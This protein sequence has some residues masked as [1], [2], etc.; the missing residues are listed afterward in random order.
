[1]SKRGR[2]SFRAGWRKEESQP[3]L[4]A[5]NQ[6]GAADRL[7]G[8]DGLGDEGGLLFDDSVIDGSAEA[9]VEN[10]D[11]EQ[12]STGGGDGDVKGQDLVSEPGE[13]GLTKS[14]DRGAATACFEGP[15]VLYKLY[16]RLGGETIAKIKPARKEYYRMS[17]AIDRELHDA[18]QAAAASEG[19]KMTHV[20]LEFIK[21]YVK[22]H[23]PA[24]PIKKGGRQ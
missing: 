12:F 11:A 6:G 3:A 13:S 15:E 9:F 21:R 22:Q 14:F 1:M 17:F 5:G 10:F 18:F 16:I 4:A 7:Q 23:P 2:S 19:K 20:I 24:Q 8:R